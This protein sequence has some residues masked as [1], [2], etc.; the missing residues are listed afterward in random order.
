MKEESLPEKQP[1]TVRSHTRLLTQLVK[2]LTPLSILPED[3]RT[4][5]ALGNRV[6]AITVRT[7]W[8]EKSASKLFKHLRGCRHAGRWARCELGVC[9]IFTL[10]DTN[11]LITSL[12]TGENYE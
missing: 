5:G 10:A 7:S 2:L 1:P 11:A 4:Q 3:V 8:A 9:G 6:I 12:T